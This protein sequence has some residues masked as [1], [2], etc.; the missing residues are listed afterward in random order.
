VLVDPTGVEHARPD[1]QILVD[2]VMTTAPDDEPVEAA[3]VDPDT[4]PEPE[5]ELP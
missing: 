3:L 2:P 5:L 4:L 1:L